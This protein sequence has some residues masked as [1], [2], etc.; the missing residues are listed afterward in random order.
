M[1]TGM[2]GSTTIRIF[3][4][5][6]HFQRHFKA[7]VDENTGAMMNF[8]AAQ[9]W[10]GARFQVL[11]SF[12]VLFAAFF[13]VLFNDHLKLDTGIIAMLIIWSTNFTITL[14]FFSQAVSE[15]EAYLTSV[16]RLQDMTNLPQEKRHETDDSV[17]LKSSW[18]DE[19]QLKFEN[20]CLRYRPGL[21]LAL[22]GL[23]FIAYP[24]Q[25]IGVCGRTG[26]GKS[27]IAAALFRLCEL[28]SGKIILDGRDLSTLGLADVRGRK[29]GMCI[30]PQDPVL[31]SG[32][33]RECLDP[34]GASTDDQIL[35]ALQI[36]QVADARQRGLEALEDYVDE[37]GRNF[38][39]G[40]RQLLCLARAVLAKPKVLVLDEATASVDGETDAFIQQMI[41][42][43]FSGTTM[44]TI[45]HRLNTIM[46]Y[47]KVLVMDKGRVAEFGSPK[48]LLEDN[49]G[50]FSN[51]VDS[52]GNESSLVLRQMAQD[53]S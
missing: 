25:R 46:D 43:R 15:T 40:E 48:D 16:E 31:F 53:A 38:S 39:V 17:K 2:D 42:K 23:S 5:S 30:I 26:A 19:G 47:D 51:L 50:L 11:G 34:W 1:L 18:P 10:L 13:V 6:G 49:N 20:V 32:S 45:A 36:V 22:N 24:G 4:K 33:I 52:T 27:T 37:G 14:G 7:T 28:E 44:L 29:K 21:P 3:G 12:V 41:R 9:R 35:E 8:M